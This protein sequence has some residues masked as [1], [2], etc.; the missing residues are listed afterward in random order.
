M[1]LRSLCNFLV[2]IRVLSIKDVIMISKFW[3][4][5]IIF[6]LLFCFTCSANA[7]ARTPDTLG[8]DLRRDYIPVTKEQYDLLLIFQNARY[9]RKQNPAKAI[10][11]YQEFYD[12]SVREK[13]MYYAATALFEICRVYM[14]QHLYF[15]AMEYSLRAYQVLA[16]NDLEKKSNYFMIGIGNC[17][18][19][20]GNYLIA[21]GDFKK[22]EQLFIQ[23]NDHFGIAVAQNNI[24][25]CKQKLNQQDSALVYF[26]RALSHRNKTRQPAIIGHSYYYIGTAYANLGKVEEARRYFNLAIPLLNL[27]VDDIFLRHDL[28]ST[29]GEVYFEL[30]KLNAREKEPKEAILN[31]TKALEIFDTIAEQVK[32]PPVYIA[33][34]YSYRDLKDFPL[35]MKAYRDALRIAYSKE[36]LDVEKS[37]YQNMIQVFQLTNR[38]DSVSVYLEKFYHVTDTIQAQMISSRFNE[39][40]LA[41][42]IREAENESRTLQQ[43]SDYA[44]V[45]FVTVGFLMLLLIIISLIYIRKQRKNAKIAAA[46]IKARVQAEKDLEKLNLEL[47][48]VNT[49]K[50]RFI[51]IMSHDLRS[52][53]NA[54]LGFAD[55]LVEETADKNIPEIR[56]YSKI[57]Q[58]IASATFQLLENLLTW[59]RLQ[60]GTIPFQPANLHLYDEVSVVIDTMMVLASRKSIRIRNLVSADAM[61]IADNNMIQA[62]FRNLISNAVKFT[63]AEGTI[64]IRSEYTE[65]FYIIRISD[66]GVGIPPEISGKL[67]L[68]TN[69]LVSTNGTENEKGHGLGLLLCRHMVEKNGGRIWLESTSVKGSTFAFTL[70][71]VKD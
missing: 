52:P 37:C 61:V 67:F 7:Q 23:N 36:L 54:L 10:E 34:G 4:C 55:L 21:E 44:I 41:L 43:K 12:K 59:S 19:Q 28:S 49:N 8:A 31:F 18:F 50:D 70:P 11:L 58:Q 25:L 48:E 6:V 33:I 35:A 24:G 15:Q 60:I 42:K 46:E 39:I 32:E 63:K 68:E 20:T 51:S 3:L 26:K 1:L 56:H 27:I 13:E 69:G 65:G 29:L 47:K 30:G 71:P 64:E 57:V 62:I 2:V 45:F 38:T 53:F 22:A 5:Q 14:D 17:Y 40:R 66:N 16:D 9:A